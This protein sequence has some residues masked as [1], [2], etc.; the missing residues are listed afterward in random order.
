MNRFPKPAGLVPGLA[1]SLG[2]IFLTA[3]AFGQTETGQ[4]AGTVSDTTGAVVNGAKVVVVSVNTSFRREGATNS[5]GLYTIPGLKADTYELT[6]ESVGFKKVTKQVQV[7]A[8]SNNEVSTQL[9]VGLETEVAEVTGSDE[10]ATVNTESQ[11]LSQVI[12]AEQIAQLPT[13]PTRNPYALVGL[14]GNLTEDIGSDRGAGYAINGMRSASTDILLDGAENVNAFNAGIGQTVPLDSVLELSVLTN[15]FTAEY[16]HAS[17]GVVNV[18][19]KS[20]SN[21]FHG[22]AYEYNRVSTLSANTY[23]NDATNTAKGT[24]TRNNFGFTLGGPFIKNKL[25][26][27]DNAEAVRVRSS[28]PTPYMIIDPASVLSM[29]PATQAFFYGYRNGH[30]QNGNLLPTVRTIATGPCSTR[31]PSSPICDSVNL[32]I[33]SDAGGGAPQNTTEEVARVDYNISD[34][35]TLFGRYASYKE[36]DFAGFVSASPYGGYNTGANQYYQ[37]LEINVARIFSATLLNTAK[38]VY[39]RLNGPVFSLGTAPVGPTLY[40][41]STVPSVSVGG[42]TFP[43]IFPGYN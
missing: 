20:G 10:A 13:S 28:S 27:F 12:T 2:L 39:N 42:N 26:F 4:I 30:F 31:L 17:G 35:T 9:T 16:G 37:N 24:F 3:I 32:D 34:K 38:V 29:A 11:T 19:T 23:Q 14:S 8:G 15:N 18:V 40:T 6:I 36:S 41:S 7:A 43:L 1:S 22:S 33:P 5:V 25:F 21:H